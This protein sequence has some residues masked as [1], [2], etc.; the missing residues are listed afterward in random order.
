ME[1]FVGTSGWVYDWNV[2][3]SLD[4]YLENSGLNAV[5]LNASFYRFPFPNQVKG[6]ARKTSSHGIRWA[7]KVYRGITHFKRLGGNSLDLWMKF[8][9]LFKPLD[10]YIDFYLFQ[11]PPTFIRTE[12]SINR[13]EMFARAV[14]LGSRLAIEFRH[15][16]WFLEEVVEICRNLGI[17]VVSID[18]PIGRWI[19]SSNSIVY[20]RL[21]GT[22][23]WYGYNYSFKQLKEIAESIIS[24]DPR[25][26]YIFFN[27]NHWMLENAQT[28]LNILKSSKI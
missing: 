19:V 25:K 24:L 13:I 2:G 14:N 8:Y 5:E 28:M 17:T 10:R 26:I 7:V 20:L 12:D 1:I 6:W 4:W 9:H 3:G 27:N 11:M 21:H 16:S 22:D 18:A 15:S 23:V